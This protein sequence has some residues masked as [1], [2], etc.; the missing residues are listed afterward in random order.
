MSDS[1]DNPVEWVRTD[2]FVMPVIP[3][4]LHIDPKTLAVPHCIL[5]FE[6]SGDDTVDPDWAV[7]AMEHVAHYLQRLTSDEIA[8]MRS[9]MRTVASWAEAHQLPPHFV[10]LVRHF[11][12]YS[13]LETDE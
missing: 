3:V 7:E 2:K 11:T 5:V 1:T 10:D 8:Q 6:L 4:E 9:D 12:E 13:G